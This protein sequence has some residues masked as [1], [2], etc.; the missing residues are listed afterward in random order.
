MHIEYSAVVLDSL[1]S[2]YPPDIFLITRRRVDCGDFGDSPARDVPFFT[3]LDVYSSH[4]ITTDEN[5]RFY[6]L[7]VL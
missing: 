5:A 4:N 3:E 1:K 6:N 2:I 7:P